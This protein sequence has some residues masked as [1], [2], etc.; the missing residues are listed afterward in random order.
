MHCPT[1]PKLPTFSFSCEYINVYVIFFLSK[2]VCFQT[3][4]RL[5]LSHKTCKDFCSNTQNLCQFRNAPGQLQHTK[6]EISHRWGFE[7]PLLYNLNA[8]I[9][10][11]SNFSLQRQYQTTSYSYINRFA[12]SCLVCGIKIIDFSITCLL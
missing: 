6:K 7:R 2:I 4:I 5:A 3:F 12:L 11:K 9:I 10:A 1:P 8:A